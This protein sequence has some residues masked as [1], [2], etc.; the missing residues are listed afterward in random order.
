MATLY[1]ECEHNIWSD[2]WWTEDGPLLIFLD[3]RPSSASYGKQITDCPNCGRE[4]RLE[5]LRSENYSMRG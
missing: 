2:L 5:M 1:C 3:N 4:L